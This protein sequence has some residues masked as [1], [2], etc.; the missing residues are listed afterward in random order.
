MVYRTLF[1][2]FSVVVGNAIHAQ[3]LS[4][5]YNR[6]NSKKIQSNDTEG[7]SFVVL[8]DNLLTHQ[9][10]LFPDGRLKASESNAFDNA[11]IVENIKYIY[12]QDYEKDVFQYDQFGNKIDVKSYASENGNQW[13]STFHRQARFNSKNHR[14]YF[15]SKGMSAGDYLNMEV[16]YSYDYNQLRRNSVEK[17]FNSN[18]HEMTSHS[19]FSRVSQGYL[20]DETERGK[21]I[22]QRNRIRR[23]EKRSNGG[24][25]IFETIS[26]ANK[27]IQSYDSHG[28]LVEDQFLMALGEDEFGPK[29]SEYYRFKFV[30]D[31]E[32][33]LS[34][35]YMTDDVGSSKEEKIE[36]SYNSYGRMVKEAIYKKLNNGNWKLMYSRK[37]GAVKAFYVP[38]IDES[39]QGHDY[40]EQPSQVVGNAAY[41]S[42][43]LD[44]ISPLIDQLTVDSDEVALGDAEMFNSDLV[45]LRQLARVLSSQSND[46][47]TEADLLKIALQLLI[48][49]HRDEIRELN[50]EYLSEQ[51]ALFDN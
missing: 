45:K 35:Q 7:N 29:Y 38:T 8:N 19:G 24:N 28:R 51:A 21:L 20:N 4:V 40:V 3:D 1:I 30:Y 47:I 50:Q 15:R 10:F 32:G 36:Y 11:H 13:N 34:T 33:N 18:D 41:V 22:N 12:T 5:Q 49:K 48:D 17:R 16:T 43:D 9:E 23:L 25:R 46:E 42:A 27:S 37:H 44:D 26:E 39:H 6:D 31:I 2:A 14:T